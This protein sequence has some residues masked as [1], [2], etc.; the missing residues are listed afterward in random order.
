MKTP[1]VK[2]L[3]SNNRA[4]TK[5]TTAAMANINTH[6][7]PLT[8]NSFL[9]ATTKHNVYGTTNAALKLKILAL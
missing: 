6:I 7:G 9:I 1:G 3:N 2:Y 8:S 5:V 4:G